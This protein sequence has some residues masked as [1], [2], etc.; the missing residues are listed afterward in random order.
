MSFPVDKMLWGWS[1]YKFFFHVSV[2]MS[3]EDT[4]VFYPNFSLDLK[5]KGFLL[6][7]F[8]IF[9]VNKYTQKYLVMVI[10]LRV[11]PCRTWLGENPI[12]EENLKSA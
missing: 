9:Q 4:T 5:L 1:F 2:I 3:R 8:H 11:E 7:S 12:M 10:F 6:S